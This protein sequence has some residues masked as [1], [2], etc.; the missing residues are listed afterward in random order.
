MRWNGV[1]GGAFACCPALTDKPEP[2]ENAR[3]PTCL[4]SD[5]HEVV[6]PAY[7]VY[8]SKEKATPLCDM[9][10]SHTYTP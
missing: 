6:T 2:S 1:M 7:V 10:T 3:A 5:G 8:L 4:L 9:A